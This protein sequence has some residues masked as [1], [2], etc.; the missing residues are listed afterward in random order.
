MSL[1]VDDNVKV[2]SPV[3]PFFGKQGMVEEIDDGYR[4]L[5]LIGVRFPDRAHLRWY[6]ELELGP[7]GV[8]APTAEIPAVA[9]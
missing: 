7:V 8:E 6:T 3:A 9:V 5:P 2:T 4:V 1:E